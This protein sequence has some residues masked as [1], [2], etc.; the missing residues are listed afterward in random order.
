MGTWAETSVVSLSMSQ[1]WWSMAVACRGAEAC[2]AW[3]EAARRGCGCLCLSGGGI[4]ARAGECRGDVDVR[5]AVVK[6]TEKRIDVPWQ[7]VLEHCAK[8]VKQYKRK[9]KNP[10]CKVLRVL[11]GQQSINGHVFTRKCYVGLSTPK[12]HR[13][14]LQKKKTPPLVKN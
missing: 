14:R 9:K 3:H 2:R 11:W 1:L 8:N 6:K 10:L 5:P 13:N 7:L 4:G 12:V